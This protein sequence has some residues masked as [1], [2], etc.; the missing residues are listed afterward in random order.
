MFGMGSGNGSDDAIELLKQDHDEAESL[1][2]QYEDAK[3][4]GNVELKVQIAAAACRALAVHA[5]VE[6]EV[7][8]PALRTA[9]ETATDLLDEA[10]VEHAAVKQLVAV[11]EAGS[12][13]DP[14]YD[15]SVR[16]L[17]EYVKHHVKEEEGEIFPLARKADLDLNA[18]AAT[19]RTRKDAL[20][21]AP[22]RRRAARKPA[23]R[24]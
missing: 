7:F 15:A 6:E 19:M 17:G 11:I 12:P 16:V 2:D 23:A 24:H 20:E 21:A 10:L 1:F 5:A 14:L 3:D 22:A 13:D 18:L 8:Y 9:D 4:E